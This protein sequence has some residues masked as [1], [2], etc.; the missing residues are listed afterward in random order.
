M[1]NEDKRLM[2]SKAAYEKVKLFSVELIVV[3]WELL[4]EKINSE[5]ASRSY[6]YPVIYAFLCMIIT[7][8]IAYSYKY[9]A[10]KL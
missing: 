10:F 2:M 5:S 1:P 9:W 8:L 6:N 7:G 4:F 3:Q